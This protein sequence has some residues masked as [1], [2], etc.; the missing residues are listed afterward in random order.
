MQGGKNAAAYPNKSSSV[1]YTKKSLKYSIAYGKGLPLG[2]GGGVGVM[3][4]VEKYG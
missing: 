3:G 4:V 1:S 2:G